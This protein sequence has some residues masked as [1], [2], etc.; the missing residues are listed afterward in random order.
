MFIIL[1]PFINK[2][3]FLWFQAQSMLN[4]RMSILIPRNVDSTEIMRLFWVMKN[5]SNREARYLLWSAIYGIANK[6]YSKSRFSEIM[7]GVLSEEELKD[8]FNILP[9]EDSFDY[10]LCDLIKA[11]AVVLNSEKLY[12]C[13]MDIEDSIVN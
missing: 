12:R 13:V 2:E 3:E 10:E 9:V 5:R 6:S 1:P 11:Y 8:I 7:K 4:M